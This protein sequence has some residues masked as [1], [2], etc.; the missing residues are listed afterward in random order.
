MAT[1]RDIFVSAK[2]PTAVFTTTPDASTGNPAN[3]PTN[4]ATSPAAEAVDVEYFAWTLTS[5]PDG[6]TQVSNSSRAPTFTS[7]P[8]GNY[9]LRLTVKGL[10]DPAPVSTQKRLRIN[11][12]PAAPG[13]PTKVGQGCCDTWGDFRFNAVPG[14]DEYEVHM[15]GYFLGGCRHGPQRQ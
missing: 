8:A 5:Y 11:G 2:A 13:P 10:D 15:D 7:L 9:F 14:A 3:A 1:T 12:T 4:I 6:I